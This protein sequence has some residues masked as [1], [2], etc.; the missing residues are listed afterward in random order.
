MNILI[1]LMSIV[2]LIIAPH[3]AMNSADQETKTN[4]KKEITVAKAAAKPVQNQVLYR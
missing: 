1:K 2:S 3:I 4:A